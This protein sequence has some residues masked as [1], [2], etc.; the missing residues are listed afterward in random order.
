MPLRSQRAQLIPKRVKRRT[1]LHVPG[2]QRDKRFELQ[3]KN[4]Q[5]NRPRHPVDGSVGLKS[6]LVVHRSF[7]H[8]P[9]QRHEEHDWALMYR[10]LH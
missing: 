9:H 3:P 1:D 4:R 6:H 7:A 2:S 5:A 8:C 10:G